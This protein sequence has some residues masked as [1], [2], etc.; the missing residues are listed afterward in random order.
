MHA[1]CST[2]ELSRRKP[3]AVGPAVA[4]PL[5]SIDLEIN[6]NIDEA[7]QVSIIRT[8]ANTPHDRNI[9]I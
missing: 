5:V 2:T 6:N 3:G 9:T 8:N 1:L 7:F 4:G